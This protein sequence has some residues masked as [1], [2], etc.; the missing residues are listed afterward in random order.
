[1]QV[2]RESLCKKIEEIYPQIGQCN[3]D[4]KVDFDEETNTW[5]VTL[6][7]AGQVLKTRLEVPEAQQCTEGKQCLSLGL[8]ISQLVQRVEELAEKT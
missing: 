2:D 7:R 5:L 6:E 3:I 1:M 8:Q 4:V